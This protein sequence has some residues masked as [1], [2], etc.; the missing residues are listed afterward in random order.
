MYKAYLSGPV[1][2]ILQA[3]IRSCAHLSLSTSG[4][5]GSTYVLFNNYYTLPPFVEKDLITYWRGGV[6]EV[7]SMDCT[8]L[9]RPQKEG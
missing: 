1:V 4:R 2:C 9:D 6:L 7:A 8:V 3:C 5:V